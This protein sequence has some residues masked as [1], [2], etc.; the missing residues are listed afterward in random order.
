MKNYLDKQ[1]SSFLYP[2]YTNNDVDL[3][4]KIISDDVT[5]EYLVCL[6]NNIEIIGQVG[7]KPS[8]LFGNNLSYYIEEEY[9]NRGLGFQAVSTLIE[10][11]NENNI[12]NV[13]LFVEK[14]NVAS[15][16]IAEKLSTMYSSK[17]EEGPSYVSFHINITEKK[18]NDSEIKRH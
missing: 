11:L 6:H 16:K 17:K 18:F 4:K 5:G 12:N 1:N 14:K 3:Y 13:D 8:D 15:I 10:Y 2:I 7:F 9:R